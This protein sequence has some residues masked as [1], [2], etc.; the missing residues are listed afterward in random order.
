MPLLGQ[1]TK[2][3][4]VVIFASP[5]HCFPPADGRGLS[6]VLLLD[7]MPTPQVKEHVALVQELHPPSTIEMKFVFV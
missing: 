1:S 2:L 4:D 5:I 3:Q 6:H 7:T